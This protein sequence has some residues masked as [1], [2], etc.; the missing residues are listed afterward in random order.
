MKKLFTV[1]A[2][3]L[4][5]PFL[6]AQETVQEVTYRLYNLGVQAAQADPETKKKLMAQIAALQKKQATLIARGGPV[7]QGLSEP[8]VPPPPSA[9]VPRPSSTSGPATNWARGSYSQG[10]TRGG[11]GLGGG[12]LPNQVGWFQQ[13]GG[14]TPGNNPLVTHR[15]SY[16]TNMT[17]PYIGKNGT[18]SFAGFQFG[19][20]G[21][22]GPMFQT[23]KYGGNFFG[24]PIR[25]R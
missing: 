10:G 14:L 22:N 12:N 21:F 3:F 15:G 11:A 13:Y 8:P 18:V 7:E 23:N 6:H 5:G 16:R 1:L 17:A 9:G 4:A 20:N 24:I 25:F 2:M 19:R